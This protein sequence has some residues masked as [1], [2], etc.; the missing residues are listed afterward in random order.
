MFQE[1]AEFIEVLNE[2]I[3]IPAS[4]PSWLWNGE[5]ITKVIKKKIYKVFFISNWHFFCQHPTFKIKYQGEE[6]KTAKVEHALWKDPSE[7]E[8]FK[9]NSAVLSRKLRALDLENG[10]KS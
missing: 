7:Q 2:E 8:S 1:E 5:K 3:T 4:P 6:K 9:P 10:A